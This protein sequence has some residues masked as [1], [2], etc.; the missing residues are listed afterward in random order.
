MLAKTITIAPN[1]NTI[2][3]MCNSLEGSVQM[4]DSTTM[5]EV[6]MPIPIRPSSSAAA[7][8]AKP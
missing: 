7:A 6:L 8:A 3:P 4:R 1:S 2:R 5:I